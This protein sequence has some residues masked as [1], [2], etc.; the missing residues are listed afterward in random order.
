MNFKEWMVK[1]ILVRA[2]HK[3]ELKKFIRENRCYECEEFFKSDENRYCCYKCEN[4]CCLK[5]S[6]GWILVSDG[7]PFADRYC[8]NC[9]PRK[10]DICFDEF[11]S[12]K[13]IPICMLCRKVMCGPCV[14]QGLFTSRGKYICGNCKYFDNFT[15]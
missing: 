8:V 4:R 13:N 10:C 15:K 2:E 1:S 11:K 7:G 9:K 3:C 14:D 12:N 6:N 5:C